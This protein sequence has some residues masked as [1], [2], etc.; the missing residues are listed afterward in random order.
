M[1]TLKEQVIAQMVIAKLNENRRTS[2]Q[3]IDVAVNEGDV[4]LIGWCDHEDQRLVAAEIAAGT[5]GVRSVV[6]N[7]RVRRIAPSI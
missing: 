6:D 1:K 3:T 4:M 5:Y 2:G 7:I